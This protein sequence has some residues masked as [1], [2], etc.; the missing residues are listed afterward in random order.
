MIKKGKQ[1]MKLWI[2]ANQPAPNNGY[3]WCCSVAH[4]ILIL[5]ETEFLNH[6]SYFYNVH[7]TIDTININQDN[8]KEQDYQKMITMAKDAVIVFH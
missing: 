3:F 2:D 8:V 7:R 1:Q 6:K 4:A 5:E